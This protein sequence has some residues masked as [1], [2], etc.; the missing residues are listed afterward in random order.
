MGLPRIIIPILGY[1]T[2]TYSICIAL[3]VNGHGGGKWHIPFVRRPLDIPHFILMSLHFHRQSSIAE[4][5]A[6]KQSRGFAILM[7]MT[8]QP[9]FLV[10]S[11]E[12][13][14]TV[15]LLVWSPGL[16][17]WTDGQGYDRSDMA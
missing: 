8:S 4:L 6:C 10:H 7:L 17:W 11:T 15:V 1:S 14:Y 16:V 3:V 13:N 9:R 12:S 2:S 5:G